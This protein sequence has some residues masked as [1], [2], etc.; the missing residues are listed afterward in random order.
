MAD[1]LRVDVLGGEYTEK[2]HRIAR[3]G[4]NFTRAYCTSP[5]CVPARGS[6]FTGLYPNET[7]SII[8]PWER[9]DASHGNVRAGIRNLYGMME[10]E[11]DSWHVGKQHFLMEER[12]DRSPDSK[13]H[14]NAREKE[15]AEFLRK[16]G[17]RPP[18]GPNFK[19]MCPEMAS[20]KITRAKSYSIP[21]IGC[22]EEGLDYFFDGFFAHKAV[23][24]I[25]SR[26]KTKPFLLNLMFLAPHPPFDIPEPW[27]SMVKEIDLPENVGTWCP[28][29]SP[30]QLYN[31][32]GALGTRYR[33]E[34]WKEIWRVYLGLV[35]LLD[36]CVGMVLEALEEEGIY[37]DTLILFTADHGEMLGSHCLWQK[38]CMYEESVRIPLYMKF[39][40]GDAPKS[41]VVQEPVS[42]VDVLPTLCEY[43]GLEAPKNLSGISLMKAMK[44]EKLERKQL[45]IQFDGNG[46]RGN[47]QRCILEEEYKLIVDFFKDELY[48]ELYHVGN[49]PQELRN[50]AFDGDQAERIEAMLESL[51]RH[52]ARTGDLLDLPEN[53]YGLFVSSY[54]PFRK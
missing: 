24:A 19:G 1:Q 36:H 39:P 43:L 46:A 42:A 44:G 37:E 5:L 7:G 21:T 13:T 38:M 49:D 22:Y 50:L 15:Y 53:A 34:D 12:P 18:G 54:A 14:W 29:Q 6:F 8:N 33:R 20:G 47:F 35:G 40:K 45:F 52:M 17:K 32:T 28:N 11:W 51:R 10:Q 27:Y 23:E 9:E 26:D 3:E 31:I 16:N 41:R 4:V 25:R 30:L 2:I 48:L